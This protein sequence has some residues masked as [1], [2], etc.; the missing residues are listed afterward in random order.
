VP[1]TRRSRT[2]GATPEQVWR[3]VGDP[4]HL[5][6]WW[7]NV[8]RV[9]GVEREHFTE[10]L[11]TG[12]GRSVRADFRVLESRAPE[13]RRWA[14]EVEGSP[15]AGL[16]RSA[17]TELRLEPDGADATKVTLTIRQRLRGVGA[18]GAVMVGRATRRR[19]DEA[20]DGLERL[21]G[22]DR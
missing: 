3:T 10:V 16:L 1:R 2:I 22:T 4:H 13:L 15:F 20:L 18:F 14:Q 21:H 12:K 5:P 8:E 7:P 11:A 6:R 19:A 17:E 9:E